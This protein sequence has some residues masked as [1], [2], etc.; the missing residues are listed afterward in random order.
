MGYCMKKA[1]VGI[2]ACGV[3]EPCA[4]LPKSILN[5]AYLKSTRKCQLKISN[6]LP[7]GLKEKKRDQK[8]RYRMGVRIRN[9][10]TGKRCSRLTRAFSIGHGYKCRVG[11]FVTSSVVSEKR[12]CTPYIIRK[13]NVGGRASQHDYPWLIAESCKY[14]MGVLFSLNL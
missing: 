10:C 1:L 4:D 6:D 8:H 11:F 9:N 5:T 3:T 7:R 2:L 13:T 12:T 14:F